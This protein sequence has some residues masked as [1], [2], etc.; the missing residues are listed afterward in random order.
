[1]EEASRETAYEA[2]GNGAVGADWLGACRRMVAAQRELFEERSGITART[3][4][5]G[6][7]EGGDA[8]LEI[9][10][11]AEDSVFSELER[12]HGK[13]HEFTAISEERGKLDFGN[14]EPRVRVVIDP[15][16]GSLNA[17]RTIP[18]H[19]LSVAVASG[20]TMADVEF[21]YVYDFGAGEEYVARRGE[22][23]MLDGAAVRAEGPGYGL[24]V[25]AVEAA[26]PERS[27]PVLEALAGKAYRMRVIGSIAISLAYASAG[28]VDAMLTCRACR[29]VDAAAGQLIVREAG[30]EVAFGD[31]GLGVGLGL[32][33]RYHVA[34]AQDREMLDAVLEAQSRADPPP[35]GAA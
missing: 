35:G 6:V 4:Y 5:D 27:I 3:V 20:G 10:R 21:G 24:E 25:V 29:S 7:G 16:D 11:L 1:M 9:D 28:R 22:G 2:S 13:G 19:S 34:A 17:R 23:T 12:L 32:D 30:G 26:R 15:I 14:G 31:D 8:T 18:Q 33:Q